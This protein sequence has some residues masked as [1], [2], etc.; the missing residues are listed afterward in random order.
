M[1]CNYF[2]PFHRL[3]FHC[4]LCYAETFTFDLVPCVC[5]C[6]YCLCFGVIS[7]KA[8]DQCQRFSP[9][10]FS[11]NFSVSDLVFK[12]L[13]HF[14]FF[15]YDTRIHF[16]FFLWTSSFPNTICWRDCPFLIVCFWQ[17]YLR[18]VD[19]H[20]WVYFWALCSSP[21][22][23]VSVLMPVPYCF[24]YYGFVILAWLLNSVGVKAAEPLCNLNSGYDL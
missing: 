8:F 15:V 12:Y 23:S 17:L 22:V 13:I 3:S 4:F 6:F 18:A 9:V 20:A 11:N 24:K 16:S 10:F 21:L 2:L 19:I 7:K 5:F 1:V 14:W